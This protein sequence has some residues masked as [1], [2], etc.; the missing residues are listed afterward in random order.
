MNMLR[1]IIL[2]ILIYVGYRLF[3]GG[4]TKEKKVRKEHSAEAGSTTVSDVLVEDPVCHV[5]IPKGQAI[6]LQHQGAIVFFCS[7]ECCNA[8]I[9]KKGKEA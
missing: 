7:E 1:L 6:R 4:L 8:F 3:I 2:A 9:E 5:L